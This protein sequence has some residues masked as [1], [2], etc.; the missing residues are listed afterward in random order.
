[1][2]IFKENSKDFNY[3]NLTVYMDVDDVLL[4]STQAVLD[5]IQER[6]GVRQA[7]ENIKDWSFKS[8]KRDLNSKQIEEIFD[9]DEFWSKV[10][11]N[12]TLVDAF[13]EGLWDKFNWVFVTKGT[14]VNLKKKFEYL[15]Q[16]SFF[17]NNSNWSYYR[18]DS[19][20]SKSKVH[21]VGGIQVDDLYGNLVNTD[22]D[23]KILLKN[24]R[25]T[26]FNTPKRKTDNFENLYFADDMN[27]IVSILNWYASLDGEELNEILANMVTELEDF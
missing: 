21:M 2:K 15:M 14:E 6:Y 1:M 24:G 3:D 17:Q 16:Q 9:S 10:C 19:N 22:A 13:K 26:E 7:Q 4:D 12:K 5:I 23:L 11:L 20:E 27:H 18:L 25:D 8:A